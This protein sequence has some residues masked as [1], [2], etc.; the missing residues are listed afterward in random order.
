[1]KYSGMPRKEKAMNVFIGPFSG[2]RALR[3]ISLIYER[4]HR[5][6]IINQI[7]LSFKNLK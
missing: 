2:I 4:N 1:M 7:V 5:L 6:K 3:T